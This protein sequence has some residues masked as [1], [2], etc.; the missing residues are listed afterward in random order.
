MAVGRVAVHWRFSDG[1]DWPPASTIAA[2][3]QSLESQPSLTFG[4]YWKKTRSSQPMVG[5]NLDL[6]LSSST[7]KDW[8]M[9]GCKRLEKKL[10]TRPTPKANHNIK[11]GCSEASFLS[12]LDYQPSP[13]QPLA[14][15]LFQKKLSTEGHWREPNNFWNK[16]AFG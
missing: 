8:L 5:R 14:G 10:G 6:L 16:L 2:L 12:S 13:G 4:R 7:S 1:T 11:D 9:D 15:S 3:N